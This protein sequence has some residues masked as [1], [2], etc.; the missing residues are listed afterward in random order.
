LVE[1]VLANARAQ[2]VR[3]VQ[4][5]C[6]SFNAEARAAFEALGFRPMT[7]RFQRESG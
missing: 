4:L 2:G 6:W 7:V 1:R 5:T 3:D